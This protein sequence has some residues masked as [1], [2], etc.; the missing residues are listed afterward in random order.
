LDPSFATGPHIHSFDGGSADKRRMELP[1][2]V[3]QQQ[4]GIKRER[5][6]ERERKSE[7][8]RERE[9]KSERERER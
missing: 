3:K 8:E 7:R 6:R 9:R 4:P 5:E 1:R 2:D